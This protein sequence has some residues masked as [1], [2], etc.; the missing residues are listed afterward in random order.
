MDVGDDKVRVER[1]EG[2]LGRPDGD[3]VVA[4]G[5][6]QCLDHVADARLVLDHETSGRHRRRSARHRFR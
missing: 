6:Q 5:R 3:D 1:L 4:D 2:G